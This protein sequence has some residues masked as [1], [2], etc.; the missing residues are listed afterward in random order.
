M[1]TSDE[2]MREAARLVLDALESP[3]PLC[4]WLKSDAFKEG[5]VMDPHDCRSCPTSQFLTWL[6]EKHGYKS[7]KAVVIYNAIVIWVGGEKQLL[8][9]PAWVWQFEDYLRSVIS[10][11]N[12]GLIS[13]LAALEAMKLTPATHR[14]AAKV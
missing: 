6:L 11:G 14:F 7:A 13:P 8:T 2:K 1:G 5:R 12:D 9:A 3:A 4:A 10:R